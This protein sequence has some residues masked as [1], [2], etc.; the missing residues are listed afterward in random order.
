MSYLSFDALPPANPYQNDE[1]LLASRRKNEAN[2]TVGQFFWRVGGIATC[3]S[4]IEPQL[5]FDFVVQTVEIRIRWRLSL[6]IGTVKARGER[7][8]EPLVD[9]CRDTQAHR[10]PQDICTPL[11]TFITTASRRQI[12]KNASEKRVAA[13]FDGSIHPSSEFVEWN[14]A[15]TIY[16]IVPSL[17]LILHHA[18]GGCYESFRNYCTFVIVLKPSYSDN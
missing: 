15:S 12:L 5:N 17:C 2:A 8:V 10:Y 7:W 14:G 9:K 16:V 11:L 13:F 18:P 4:N 6:S 1:G 3:S